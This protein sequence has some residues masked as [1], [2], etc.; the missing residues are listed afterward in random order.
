MPFFT[1]KNVRLH[2]YEY[3]E[4]TD[5]MFAFHGFGMRGTQFQVLE[6][7]LKTR[8]KIYSFD[9]FFHGQTELKDSSVASVRKG[10]SVK[11]FGR[12]MLEFIDA[13]NAKDKKIS[14]LSYSMGSLLAWSI[15]ETI[16][17]RIDSV[18]FIAPDGIK[19]N[20]ILKVGSQNPLINK[21]F[22]TL[23]YSP[24]TVKFILRIM[25]RL[26]YIDKSL[27][28]I[29]GQEFE[30]TETRLACYNA[31]TYTSKLTFNPDKLVHL[32]NAYHINSYF[33]FGK[34]DKL[35]PAKIGLAFSKKLTNT[36]L[37]VF[38]DGHELVNE[39][40]NKLLKQQ[41]AKHDKG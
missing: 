4:G 31:I 34:T 17:N 7:A 38:N 11:E 5:I 35:F 8:Y 1:N 37:H 3:G 13:I 41:L 14:L 16:P 26:K 27:Y 30:T 15:I 20:I 40:L 32:L 39:E 22:Y 10:L 12:D 36:H 28:T 6:S 9:L 24:K 29:L 25:H 21:L 2:Y 19:S 23:V 33:Y 18:F